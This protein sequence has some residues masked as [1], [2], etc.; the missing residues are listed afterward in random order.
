MTANLDTRRI[1]SA[2]P[3]ELRD[4]YSEILNNAPAG[5]VTTQLLQAVERGSIPPITF[6]PWLGVAKSPSVTR[7]AL[8]QN[9]SVLIR[10]FGIKQLRKAL[11]SSGWRETWEGIG[12]TAGL[13]DIFADLSVHEVRSACTAIGS[14]GR[15]ADVVAKRELFT[16]FYRALHPDRFPDSLHKTKDRRALGRFYASLVP[17]C[18]ADLVEEA[19]TSGLKGTW[20]DT[21]GKHLIKYYPEYMQKELLQSLTAEQSST[22]DMSTFQDLLHHCPSAKST[23]AGFSGSM[24]FSLKVLEVLSNS[25]RRVVEDGI[26]IDQLVNPLLKRAIKNRADWSITQQIVDLTMHYL[27]M[28]PSTGCQ[29]TGLHGGFLQQVAFCW[30]QQPSLFEQQLRR[31]CSHSMF[32][33]ADKTEIGDWNYVLTEIPAKQKYPLLRFCYQASTSLDLDSDDDLAKT[34]GS[35]HHSFFSNMSPEDSLL[36]LT[37]LRR[38]RGDTGLIYL[39]YGGSIFSLP[40]TFDGSSGDPNVIHIWLLNLN[41]KAEEA[42]T[43]AKDYITMRKKKAATASQPDQRAFFAQSALF[44]TMATGSLQMLRHTLEWTKRFLGDLAVIREIYPQAYPEEGVRLLSGIPE[45]INKDLSLTELQERVCAANLILQGMFDTACEALKEPSFQAYNWNGVFELFYRV[46]KLRINLTPMVKKQLRISDQEVLTYL[47]A[48]TIPMI[49]AI[50]EKAQKEGYERLEA[51]LF[52]GIIAYNK[53]FTYD[54]E[55]GDVSTYTFLDSLARAR[56]ELWCKLRP[57]KHPATVALPHPFSRGLPIQYLT[58]PWILNVEDLSNVA[59]YI[60]SRTRRTVFPDPETALQPVPI[61]KD[62][63]QAIGMFVDSYQHALE[64][65]IPQGRNKVETQTRVRKAWEYAT[66]PLSSKRMAEDE[67]IRFWS[68]KKLRLMSEWPPQGAMSTIQKPWP[69]IPDDDGSGEPC[70][71]NPF[72]SRPD[73]PARELDELTYV[74]FSVGISGNSTSRPPVN[75]PVVSSAVIPAYTED[76][77]HLWSKKRDIGEGGVLSALLYLDTK[78]VS[79][80]RLLAT[81]FPSAADVRYTSLFL[82]EDFLTAE[83]PNQYTAARDISGHLDTIPPLLLAQSSQNLDKALKKFDADS[84]KEINANPLEV[85]MELVARLGES[86]RPSLATQSV[87]RT[88]LNR[89]ESSSWHRKLLKPSFLRRLPATQAEACIQ[90]FTDGLIHL[91]RTKDKRKKILDDQK[92]ESGDKRHVKVTTR[93]MLAQ[94]F[95][96]LDLVGADYALSVL[97]KLSKMDTHVDVRLNIIKS[98]LVLLASSSGEQSREVFTLLES[99]V[100]LAGALDEREPLNEARWVKCEQTLSLPELQPGISGISSSDSPTLVALLKYLRDGNI[101]TNQIQSFVDRIVMPILQSLRDQTARWVALFLRKYG[102]EGMLL[103]DFQIPSIPRD[104]SVNMTLLSM[105]KGK[106]SHIPRGVL[107]EYVTFMSSRAALPAPMQAMNERLAADPALRS[108]PEVEAWMRLYGRTLEVQGDG[109]EFFDIIGL[110]DHAVESSDDAAIT[111]K[112]VQEQF[113]K[114]FTTLV[115]NDTPT[116][117]NLT[118]GLCEDLLAGRYLRKTW[119]TSYGKPILEA[120]VSYVDNLRTREWGRDPARKPSVLPDTFSWRLLLLDYPWPSHDEKEANREE[121]C[122]VFAGQLVAIADQLSSLS[123]YHTHLDQLST[124]LATSIPSSTGSQGAEEHYGVWDI[125]YETQYM[126][127]DALSNNRVLTA[128]HVGDIS[129]TRLSWLTAPELLRVEIAA[130]LVKLVGVQLREENAAVDREIRVRLKVLVD[131]WKACENEGVRRR[132]WEIEQN[133]LK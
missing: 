107:E 84:E 31:L 99:F 97:Q 93:K 3:A 14:C 105:E 82:D 85:T 16:E 116:Y 73:Y 71:W 30:S 15:G 103:G 123:V 67:A 112:V 89:P 29:I 95:Q 51:N 106:L 6:A 39:D 70:E 109:T 126:P 132:G 21:R 53:S 7:E 91:L 80:D 32:G 9:I 133:Y 68:N 77:R 25:A 69:S 110:L 23:A 56:D 111:P 26:F 42:K 108:L 118:K 129:K 47:W 27:D 58:A 86:D 124:Y 46:V 117:T 52:R 96:D 83:E 5:E 115:W 79:D 18:S 90:A 48:D 122:K 36:L 101:A 119:W 49:I 17:A 81:P 55:S 128:I 63:Q 44:A 88:V 127:H 78:Y 34:K 76:P 98:L 50:E 75:L 20:K 35:V 104:P 40:L 66:G 8:T 38:V 121:R 92:V 22:V 102:L 87:V 131:T 64:L 120:M 19:I 54:L 100:P 41:D 37:R 10:K 72:S 60:A 33:T 28:H 74:D 130:I 59:P 61:D 4:Y 12:G 45:S 13:L 57:L 65:Y 11:C 94:I 62:S 43:M 114:L 2:T 125:P 113:L 1:R 24:D